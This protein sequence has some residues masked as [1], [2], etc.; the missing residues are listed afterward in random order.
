LTSYKGIVEISEDIR[1]LPNIDA[2]RVY[3]PQ[4][5]LKAPDSEAMFDSQINLHFDNV[6][7]AS[8]NNIYDDSITN[9]FSRRYEIRTLYE[10][11]LPLKFGPS[12]NYQTIYWINAYEKIKLSILSIG[13][14]FKYN[15]YNDE[16]INAH[17]IFGAEVALLYEGSSNLNYQDKYSAQ[18]FDLGLESEWL[19]PVGIITF[20]SHLRHHEVAL[21]ETNR[22][23]ITSV[24]REFSINSLSFLVGYKFK[25]EL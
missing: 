13:P 22:L 19:S 9:T 2:Q 23:N 11:Q 14:H 12:L 16:D 24:P 21:S 8:F 3:P 18:L 4:K 20:G 7:L 10:S 25:W 15:F 17:F 1:L 5:S 6:Q